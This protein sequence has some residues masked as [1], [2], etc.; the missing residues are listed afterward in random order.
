[1]ED[2]IVD[3]DLTQADLIAAVKETKPFGD[4]NR[5]AVENIRRHGRKHGIPASKFS[6]VK[7]TEDKTDSAPGIEV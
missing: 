2:S 3:N 7:V 6:N 4:S 1:M 5:E